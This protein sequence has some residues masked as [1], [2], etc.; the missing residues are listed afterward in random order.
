MYQRAFVQSDGQYIIDYRVGCDIS[1]AIAVAVVI[2]TRK[3]LVVIGMEEMIERKR[4]FGEKVKLF[5]RSLWYAY[6]CY[7]TNLCLVFGYQY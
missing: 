3:I 7:V 5:E 4:P 6:L 2:T 1:L